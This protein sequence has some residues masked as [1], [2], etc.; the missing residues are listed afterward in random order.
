VSTSGQTQFLFRSE[1]HLAR[2]LDDSRIVSGSDQSEVAPA[3]GVTNSAVS[4]V[5]LQLRVVPGIESLHAEFKP[6][7]FRNP[8]EIV[9]LTYAR[10]FQ[11]KRYCGLY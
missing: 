8:I 7:V 4:Y 6:G 1:K 3:E 9:F 10:E 2:E 11:E 5:C